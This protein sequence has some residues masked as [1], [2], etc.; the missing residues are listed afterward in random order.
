MVLTLFRVEN[1][2]GSAI[3]SGNAKDELRNEP[4]YLTQKEADFVFAG[5]GTLRLGRASLHKTS[6]R[7]F[8]QGQS[9]P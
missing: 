8:S 4:I 6:S 1:G 7:K 3:G 5:V 9:P 2:D